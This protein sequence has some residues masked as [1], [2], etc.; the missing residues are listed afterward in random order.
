[1]AEVSLKHSCGQH[2]QYEVHEVIVLFADIR[3]GDALVAGKR[4]DMIRAEGVASTNPAS[5][6]C[7]RRE[8]TQARAAAFSLS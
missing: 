3:S 5:S 4:N 6:Q 2:V 1:M 7:N 8:R